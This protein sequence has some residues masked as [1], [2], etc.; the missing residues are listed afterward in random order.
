MV[1]AGQATGLYASHKGYT[2]SQ[3]CLNQKSHPVVLMISQGLR[4][5]QIVFKYIIH[6]FYCFLS[7]WNVL[8]KYVWIK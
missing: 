2:F 4:R 5:K 8:Y 6:L 1:K 3:H 7:R